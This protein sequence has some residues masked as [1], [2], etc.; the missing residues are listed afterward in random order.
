MPKGDSQPLTLDSAHDSGTSQ[1]DAITPIASVADDVKL[2]SYDLKVSPDG[3]KKAST[4]SDE[5][6]QSTGQAHDK[7]TQAHDGLAKATDGFTFATTLGEVL[8]SWQSRL[9]MIHRDCQDLS[10][11]FKLAVDAHHDNDD[12][13]RAKVAAMRKG[14]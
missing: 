1:P 4:A 14:L 3:L 11:L 2:A 8:K 7:L 10:G 5:L 12:T 6:A 13:I 9:D